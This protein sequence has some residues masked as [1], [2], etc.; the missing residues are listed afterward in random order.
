MNKL[1]VNVC[2]K[3]LL[4]FGGI[5][6]MQMVAYMLC[7]AGY[8]IVFTAG[9][10]EYVTALQKVT[11]LMNGDSSFLMSV[12]AVSASLSLIWCGI[13]YYKSSW[14]VRN[15]DYKKVFTGKN[16]LFI[17]GTAI[18]GCIIV[19][20]ILSAISA[21][22]PSLFEDYSELMSHFDTS[23]FGISIIYVLLIGPISEEF[24]FRG[25][26]FDRFHLGFAFWLANALQAFLFAVYHMNIIQ[27]IYAFCLGFILGMIV[28]S[29]GSILC[30]IITH[31]LFNSTTYI[32]PI[33][34]GTKVLAIRV[35]VIIIMVIMAL[36]ALIGIRYF[37]KI[38]KEK[39]ESDEK[40]YIN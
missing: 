36:L 23:G 39:V 7:F 13:L 18:G 30:S 11:N 14:R 34:L 24:I 20:V 21:A 35:I 2:I 19:T 1:R 22:F 32:L 29:T 12:S 28:Y 38:S 31:I 33:I 37:G 17:I 40:L 25:A 6:L 27:G 10:D 16:I 5:I 4:I 3:S 26:L 15:M 9:G 8:I